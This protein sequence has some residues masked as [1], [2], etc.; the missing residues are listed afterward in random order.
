MTTLLYQLKELMA[1]L[2]S[3][4]LFLLM[5]QLAT[6]AQSKSS[7]LA[8][9]QVRRIFFRTLLF[10]PSMSRPGLGIPQMSPHRD[11]RYGTGW[12][13]SGTRQRSSAAFG[14]SSRLDT[15]FLG[16]RKAAL[17]YSS[18]MALLLEEKYN[19]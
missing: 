10:L 17:E 5:Q 2:S 6:H 16:S 19:T 15:S 8:C 7:C 1:S 9:L 11:P 18:S 12:R 14:F 3:A 4:L 13:R